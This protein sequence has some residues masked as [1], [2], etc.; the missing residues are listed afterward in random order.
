MHAPSARLY[1]HVFDWPA[2]QS[3]VVAGLQSNIRKAWLLADKKQQALAV[4]RVNA[5][6]V[7]I[8]VPKAAVDPV[9]TVIVAELDG[10][11]RVDS[12]L[13][14]RGRG[15][16]LLHVFDG[17]LTG[18]GAR[19]DDGKANKDCVTDWSGSGA[20]VSWEVRVA[21][22]IRVALAAEYA[23]A[24]GT[25]GTFEVRVGDQRLQATVER[26]GGDQQFVRREMG[27]LSLP[28]GH[29]RVTVAPTR[30]DGKLMRL[31]GLRWAPASPATAAP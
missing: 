2:D 14:L 12:S 4:K 8:A 28:P 18:E 23:A 10:P 27:T 6:D 5:D 9:D 16:T 30:V 22:P 1:L 7:A 24:D 17:Q 3:I 26:T 29:Y 25:G 31:R 15:E 11:A 13:L 19:Y 21:E 20:T